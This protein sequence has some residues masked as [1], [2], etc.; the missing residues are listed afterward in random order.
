MKNLPH[1]QVL[2]IMALF[3]VVCFLLGFLVAGIWQ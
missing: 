2:S 3:A 1:A